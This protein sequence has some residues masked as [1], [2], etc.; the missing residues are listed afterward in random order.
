MNFKSDPTPIVE[1]SPAAIREELNEI[2]RECWE[3]EPED[4]YDLA[5]AR[6]YWRCMP[7]NDL[8]HELTSAR[9]KLL[10]HRAWKG[11]KK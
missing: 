1:M 8:R 9:E 3:G 7:L 2:E 4:T 6:E 10:H 5:G 11:K